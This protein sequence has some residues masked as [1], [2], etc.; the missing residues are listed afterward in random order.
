MRLILDSTNKKFISLS[1]EMKMINLY[2]SLEQ[3]RYDDIFKHE[4]ILDSD[5]NPDISF[6]PSNILQP[7]IENA[8]NHG[9][10]PKQE[11]GVLNIRFLKEEKAIVCEI[12]DNGIGREKAQKLKKNNHI[13]RALKMIVERIDILKQQEKYNIDLTFTDLKDV[14]GKSLG[15]KV[16]LKLPNNYDSE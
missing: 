14:M 7:F 10:A 12:E 1:D 9:L 6:I 5:I 2:I 4:L 13:S 15:T 8:I 3:L 16:T 11:G